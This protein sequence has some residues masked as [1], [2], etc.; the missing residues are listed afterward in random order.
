MEPPGTAPGSDPLITGAFMSIVPVA[1]NVANI[2]AG[3]V[4]LKAFAVVASRRAIGLCPRLVPGARARGLDRGIGALD[5]L[6]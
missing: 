2:G 4:R 6:R 1:G 3:G 5:R